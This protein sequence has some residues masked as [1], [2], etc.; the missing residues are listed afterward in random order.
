MVVGVIRK[1]L[2]SSLMRCLQFLLGKVTG[3]I[4]LNYKERV[5]T[6]VKVTVFQSKLLPSFDLLLSIP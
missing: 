5:E 2:K 4:P 1:M 3:E 6:G